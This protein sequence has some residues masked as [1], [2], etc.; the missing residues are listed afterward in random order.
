MLANYNFAIFFHNSPK[1][2]TF[3]DTIKVNQ[4]HDM[5]KKIEALFVKNCTDDI[6]T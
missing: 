6:S 1:I 4:K 2:L 5:I 3:V